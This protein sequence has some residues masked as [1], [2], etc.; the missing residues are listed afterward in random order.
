M[1]SRSPRFL[2]RIRP[3]NFVSRTG[4]ENCVPLPKDT[5]MPGPRLKK[6]AHQKVTSLTPLP[7]AIDE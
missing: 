2:K 4:P 7:P 1:C 5:T 3:A 6:L